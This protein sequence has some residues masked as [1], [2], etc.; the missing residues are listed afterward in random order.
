MEEPTYDHFWKFHNKDNMDVHAV[1]LIEQQAERIKELELAKT[2]GIQACDLLKEQI[3]E[4]EAEMEEVSN[5]LY[6]LYSE[7]ADTTEPKVY[8]TILSL[9]ERLERAVK[10]KGA[11]EGNVDTKT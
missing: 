3:E 2:I 8:G 7:C 6:E 9:H 4:L 5:Q 11:K 1:A 10:G